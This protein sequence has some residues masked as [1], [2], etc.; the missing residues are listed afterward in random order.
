VLTL[1]NS[2]KPQHQINSQ[3]VLTVNSTAGYRWVVLL[4]TT[5]AQATLALISQ[6]MGTLSPFFVTDLGLTKSQV[7]FTGGAVNLGMTLTA[8]LAGR[9]VDVWGEKKVLVFGGLA[10]AGSIFIASFV[11]SFAALMAGLMF[12]GVWAASGTPAGSKAIMN[13]FPFSQRALAL[14]I[15][16][17]ALPLGGLIAALIL[18]VIAMNFSWRMALISMSIG[19]LLGAVTCQF[20]YKDFPETANST[21]S[22]KGGTWTDIL[23]NKNLLLVNLTGI[24]YVSA[25]FTIVSYLV[26]YLHEKSALTVAVGSLF[27]ALAHFGGIVGRVFWGYVSDTFFHGRRRPVF[28]L[29]GVIAAIIALVMLLLTPSTPLW[30]LGLITWSFGFTANGWNGVWITMLSEIAGKEQA[31]TAVGMGVTLLQFGVL[32]FPPLFGYLVDRSG[33]YEISWIGLSALI[34]M[35]VVILFGVKENT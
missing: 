34:V 20:A 7:G 3:N 1:S 9:A 13:W 19:T 23:R 27:L 21:S 33:S 10:T 26:L 28:G 12:T 35:G 5:F 8:L 22:K 15:R 32:T 17:T 31:G 24:T 18:P 2:Q 29:I 4:V 6:G 14:G 11:H 16:Q 30:L 25:Q